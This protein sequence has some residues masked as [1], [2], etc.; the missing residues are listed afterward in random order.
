MEHTVEE[1]GNIRLTYYTPAFQADPGVD[2][3]LD[4]A[5]ANLLLARNRLYD[6]LTGVPYNPASGQFGSGH[7]TLTAPDDTQY[8]I[9]TDNGVQEMIT[10]GGVPLY[11]SDAGIAT[12]AGRVD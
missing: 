2:Y 8:V 5:P 12:A 9:H 3:T 6:R 7:Y 4:A 11:Y 10:P 1:N